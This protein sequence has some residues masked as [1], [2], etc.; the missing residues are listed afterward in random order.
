MKRTTGTRPGSSNEYGCF[1]VEYRDDKGRFIGMTWFSVLAV[2]ARG[3]DGII[4]A[5]IARLRISCKAESFRLYWPRENTY[6]YCG[7]I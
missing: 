7:T 6:E 3:L 5:G 4:W 2:H 1:R